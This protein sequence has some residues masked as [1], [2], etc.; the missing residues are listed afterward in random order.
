MKTTKFNQAI[1]AAETTLLTG[2]IKKQDVAKTN[3][4]VQQLFVDAGV[5]VTKKQVEDFANKYFAKRLT[6]EK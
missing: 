4:K 2:K 6:G 1:E 5:N 3:A